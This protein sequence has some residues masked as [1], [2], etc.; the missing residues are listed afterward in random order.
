[1]HTTLI[2]NGRTNFRVVRKSHVL[3]SKVNGPD[4]KTARQQQI[5]CA[6]VPGRCLRQRL[7]LAVA[8]R[9]NDLEKKLTLPD[10]TGDATP[11]LVWLFVSKKTQSMGREV[12]APGTAVASLRDAGFRHQGYA[13]T[14][15]RLDAFKE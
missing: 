12:A 15:T 2:A 9:E 10:F 5:R 6:L 3:Q 4:F 1:M 7:D 13:G 14:R 8:C 11:R